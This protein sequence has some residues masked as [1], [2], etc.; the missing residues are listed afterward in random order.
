MCLRF[1]RCVREDL[2]DK[3][4]IHGHGVIWNRRLNRFIRSHDAVI[5]VYDEAGSSV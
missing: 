2:K 5:R 1:R 4:H 3:A